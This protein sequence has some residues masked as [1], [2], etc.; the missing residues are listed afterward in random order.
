MIS[1]IETRLKLD[2]KQEL[3]VNSCLVLWSI[4]YRKTWV[5][6]NNKHLSESDIYSPVIK[7]YL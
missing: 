7:S 5:M 2:D 6:F 4:Y 1:T 3:T